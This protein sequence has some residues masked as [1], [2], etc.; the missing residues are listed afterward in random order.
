MTCE[1]NLW[2]FQK[3]EISLFEYTMCHE[4]FYVILC[5]KRRPF[6]VIKSAFSSFISRLFRLWLAQVYACALCCQIRGFL[7][8]LSSNYKIINAWCNYSS[9]NPY[10]LSNHQ[11]KLERN[12]AAAWWWISHFFSNRFSVKLTNLNYLSQIVAKSKNYHP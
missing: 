4:V 12:P 7:C 10:P 6:C 8:S 5:T 1:L 11:P 9:I 3:N 2:Q